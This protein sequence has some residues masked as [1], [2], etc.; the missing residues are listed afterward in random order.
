QHQSTARVCL[1]HASKI[2]S[3]LRSIPY[4]AYY[5]SLS[6][7]IAVSYILLYDQILQGPAP[8]GDLLRL[9]KI[10]K[11]S[12]LEV[13]T[14]CAQDVRVHITGIGTLEN[15]ESIYGLLVDVEKMLRSQRPWQR[16]ARALA[17]CFSQI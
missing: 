1:W 11:K 16:I 8:Q 15:S 4:P 13:W 10:V 5:F 17:C 7:P 9:D 14:S 12:D 2:Y 6:L 3:S